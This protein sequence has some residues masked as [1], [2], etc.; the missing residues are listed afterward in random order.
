MVG[1]AGG[2]QELNDVTFTDQQLDAQA[3]S[4]Y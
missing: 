3:E 4:D 2:K 1:L